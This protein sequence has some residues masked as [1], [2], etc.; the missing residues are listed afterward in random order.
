MVT[1]RTLVVQGVRDPFGVPEPDE[2]T[3]VVI[4]PEETHALSKRPAAIGDAVTAWLLPATGT[5]PR[6]PRLPN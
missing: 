3:K 2:T 5:T 6:F 4:L 1:V